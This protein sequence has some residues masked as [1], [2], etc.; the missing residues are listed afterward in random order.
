MIPHPASVLAPTADSGD[1][2]YDTGQKN[3]SRDLNDQSH[4]VILSCRRADLEN[5]R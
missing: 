4:K 2:P 3:G 1:T 5:P